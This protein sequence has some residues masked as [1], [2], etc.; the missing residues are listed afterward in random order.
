MMNEWSEWHRFPDPRKGEL[1][2]APYG[3]GCYE[4]RQGAQSVVYGMSDHVALRMASL[5]PAPL[6]RGTRD[7]RDK[8]RCVLE[9]LG[10]VEYRTMVCTTRQEAK[11]YERKLQAHR[12]SYRLQT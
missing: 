2:I 5:L 4:L 12:V 7:N 11:E 10:S 9:H 8:R 6:G 1:L 3:P